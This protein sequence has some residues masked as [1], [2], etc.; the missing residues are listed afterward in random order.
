M[1]HKHITFTI[2]NSE[3]YQ[4]FIGIIFIY[5][6]QYLLN[7]FNISIV[8]CF[9]NN[10]NTISV[11]H[12]TVADTKITLYDLHGHSGNICWY[13]FQEMIIGEHFFSKKDLSFCACS[14]ELPPS[15]CDWIHLAIVNANSG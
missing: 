14:F 8:N 6:N 12:G 4:E 11:L 5:N 13:Y 9:H 10:T 1:Q 3:S 2:P 15:I 7:T